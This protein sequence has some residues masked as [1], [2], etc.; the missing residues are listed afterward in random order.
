[1]APALVYITRPM[2]KTPLIP[3]SAEDDAFYAAA[4]GEP[5]LC[6]RVRAP[7]QL[8]EAWLARRR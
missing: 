4:A 6:R 3:P 1:M 8:F 2:N 5:P 7:F